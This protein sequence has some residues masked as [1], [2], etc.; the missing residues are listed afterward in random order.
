MS[1]YPVGIGRLSMLYV[2]VHC[3]RNYLRVEIL[4]CPF[5]SSVERVLL[6]ILLLSI[7]KYGM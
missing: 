6:G 1:L 2:E 5:S 3:R 7:I 4:L